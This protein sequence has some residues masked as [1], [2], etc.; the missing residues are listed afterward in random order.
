MDL[1][2]LLVLVFLVM[3]TKQSARLRHQ[4]LSSFAILHIES[5]IVY[6]GTRNFCKG[7]GVPRH[8]GLMVMAPPVNPVVTG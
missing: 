1:A 5:H 3:P 6:N 2:K 8:V 4:K 7:Y